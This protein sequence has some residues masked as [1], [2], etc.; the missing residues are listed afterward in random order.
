M[1]KPVRVIHYLNQFFGGIGG[2][3]KANVPV[4]AREGPVGPG[5]ALQQALGAEGAIV[6]T[7][8]GGDNYVVEEQSTAV[9]ALED[10]ITHFKPDVLVAGP[11]FDA[12]RYGLACALMCQ[13]AQARGV[14]SVA[15]MHPENT[16]V[17][18]L[19]R[20]LVVVPTGTEL[21]EMQSILSR[22]VPLA[23]KL[24]RGEELG[25]ALEEGYLPRGFRRPL[26]R[27][28]TG[29]ERAIDMVEARM[30]GRPF[31]SE[32]FRR[33]FELVEA[34]PPVPNLAGATLALVSSGGLV[35]KGNPDR[36]ESGRTTELAHK[37]SIAGLKEF[38]IE[39]WECIHTGFYSG[40]VNERDTNYVLP[41]RSLR[42]LESKGVIGQVY[43]YFYSTAG[44]GMAVRAARR[45]G[46]GIARELKEAQVDAVV[47]VAT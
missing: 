26:T 37:Y 8:T 43:P 14:P 2:E 46:E 9:Q 5:R 28:K 6:A 31:V 36:L 33:D 42:Q 17:L 30:A 41:L 10:A 3:E 24:G 16:G 40:V 4:E 29:A 15:A 44:N 34:P 23:L 20:D 12:G 22:V 19:G 7:L 18:T 11:A 39:G 1:A 45:I 21:A 25:P 47:L 35:P 32:A 38:T 27:E 13:A